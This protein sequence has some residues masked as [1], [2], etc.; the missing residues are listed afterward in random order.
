MKEDKKPYRDE[1]TEKMHSEFTI[2]KEQERKIKVRLARE[3]MKDF[4]YSIETVCKLYDLKEE[5]F[6]N[7][8]HI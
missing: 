1:L 5:D 3:D 7:V 2:S 4:K 6:K 8:E